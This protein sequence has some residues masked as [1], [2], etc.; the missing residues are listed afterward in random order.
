MMFTNATKQNENG[1]AAADHKQVQQK[2]QNGLSMSRNKSSFTDS[3]QRRKGPLNGNW[4]IGSSASKPGR[5]QAKVK[6]GEAN[7]KYEKEA[8]AMADKVMS[9]P[10]KSQTVSNG[11]QNSSISRKTENSLISKI[12]PLTQRKEDELQNKEEEDVQEKS[13]TSVQTKSTSAGS[14]TPPST[15]QRLSSSSSNNEDIQSMLQPMADEAQTK[16]FQTQIDS[17]STPNIQTDAE[18]ETARGPPDSF[19]SSLNSSKGG[20]SPLPDETQHDM[21][22][23]FGADFSNVRVHTDS[24]AV[25]M[26]K[27]IGAQA[28]AHGSDIYFNEGKY[29]PDTNSG[30]HLL[31]HELTHTIQQGAVVRPYRAQMKAEATGPIV[32]RAGPNPLAVDKDE[33]DKDKGIEKAVQ[34]RAGPNFLSAPVMVQGGW[35]GDKLNEYASDIPGWTL[36]TVVVGYNPLTERDIERTPQ[37]FLKGLMGLVPGGNALYEKL[38]DHGLISEAFTWLNSQLSDLDLSWRRVAREMEEAWDEMSIRYSFST[39]L[40]IVKDHLYSIYRDVKEFGKRIID[41]TIELVKKA[42]LVPLGEYIRDN[43]RAWPLV[44]VLLG[45]DPISGERVERNL[46]NIASGFLMLDP[47]GEAYLNKLNESGKLQELSDW[48]DLEL[49]KLNINADTI[50]QVFSAAWDLITLDN[51]LDPINT[52]KKIFN[53]FSGPFERIINFVIAVAIK[54]LTAIKDWL[55]GQ[56]KTHAHKVPGY[57]LLTVI[58]GKDPVTQEEVPRTAENFI[59]GFMSF[60]PGGLEKFENLKKSGAIDKAFAWLEKAVAKLNLSFEAFLQ[61]FVTLWESF[62]INDLLDPIGAFEKIINIFAAPVLRIIDFAIEVGLK[63]LE[64]IFTG[65]MGSTGGRVVAIMKKTR[66]TFMKIIKNPVGFFQNLLKAIVKGFKQFGNNIFQHLLS[67]LAGWLFGALEGAGLQLPDKWDFKG[68]LSIVMQVLGLTWERVRAK[69]VKH[70]GERTVARLETAFEFVKIIATEGLAGVWNKIMEYLTGLKD[71]VFEGIRNWVVTKIVTVAIQKLATMWNPVGAVIESIIA[72]YNTVMFFI[73]RLNQILDLVESIVDSIS[74]IANGSLEQAANYVEQTMART[75]P[76][77]ISFLARLIGLGGISNAIK[78]VIK[79]IQDVV[80]LGLDKLIGWVV[81]QSRRLMDRLRG[82]GDPE[83]QNA[84]DATNMTPDQ[85]KEGARTEF[86]TWLRGGRRTGAQIKGQLPGLKQKYLLSDAKVDLS[87][88]SPRIAFFASPAIYTYLDPSAGQQTVRDGPAQNAPAQFTSTNAMMS[89]P[90]PL[91]VI[92]GTYSATVLEGGFECKASR[93]DL[94]KSVVAEKV[95]YQSHR[96]GSSR[97]PQGHALKLGRDDQKIVTGRSVLTFNGGHLVSDEILTTPIADKSYNLAPQVRQFNSPAYYHVIEKAAG[98]SLPSNERIKM[99]VNLGYSQTSYPVSQQTL[100]DRGMLSRVDDTKP[101][102]ISLPVRIPTTWNARLEALGPS[103]RLGDGG[104]SATSSTARHG[105]VVDNQAAFDTLE[106]DTDGS[107]SNRGRHHFKMLIKEGGAVAAN[108]SISTGGARGSIQVE[109]VQTTPAYPSSPDLTPRP[110]RRTIPRQ[111]SR[112]NNRRSRGR[113]TYDQRSNIRRGRHHQGNRGGHRGGRRKADPS[114]VQSDKGL[115]SSKDSYE[116][117]ADRVADHVVAG[118]KATVVGMPPISKVQQSSY[119][120]LPGRVEEPDKSGGQA[121]PDKT[122]SEMEIGIGADFSKVKVHTDSKAVQMSKDMGARA[123]AHGNDIYFNSGQY[124]PQ[125]NEGKHLLAH[126]LTHTVQQGA[127][128]PSVQKAEDPSAS[129][130]APKEEKPININFAPADNPQPTAA[131]LEEISKESIDT[132]K[133][134]KGEPKKSQAP[135]AAA[136]DKPK[137]KPVLKEKTEAQEK[138]KKKK[139]SKDSAKAKKKD[140][141]PEAGMNSFLN[142]PASVLAGQHD[143]IGEA[144]ANAFGS[145]RQK[146][147]AETPAVVA[148][149]S[150][151]TETAENT[152]TLEA[153]KTKGELIDGVT[154][155][156]PQAPKIGTHKDLAPPP[157]PEKN[158]SLLDKQKLGAFFSWFRNSFSGYLGGIATKDNG[159]NTSAGKRPKANLSG[160]SDPQRAVNQQKDGS[161]KAEDQNKEVKGSIDKNPGEKNIQPVE[162]KEENKISIDQKKSKVKTE[163]KKEMGDY[164]NLPLPKDVRDLTDQGMS[165]LLSKSLSKPKEDV[166]AATSKRDTDRKSEM[167]KAQKETAKLNQDAAVEQKKTVDDN[168]KAVLDQKKAGKDEA[169]KLK[170]GF[171]KQ[172]SNKKKETTDNIDKEVKTREKEADSELKKGETKAKEKKK[173]AEKKAKDKKKELKKSSK[174]KS[175]WERAVDAV[176]SAVKAITSAIGKIFSALRKAVSAII[177]AAKELALK[178]IDAARQFAL[179]ALD[180][181]G[182]FLKGLVNTFIGSLFPDLAKRINKAIDDKVSKA[183][184]AV[185]AVADKLKKGVTALADALKKGL[186]KILDAFETALTAAVQIVGALVTGDFVEALKIAIRSACKIAGI[187]PNTVFNFIDKAG[188]T[189]MKILKDPISF[190]KNVASGIG[191]GINKFKTNIKKHLINGLFG[192]LTG[193]MNDVPIQLPNKWDLKGIMSVVL[194]ILGL[195]YDNLR[196]KVVKKLGPKGETIVGALEKTAGILQQLYKAKSAKP[197]IDMAKA[198]FGELK[199]QAMEK[200]RGV[201]TLEVVKAGIKWLIGLL[202]PASAIVKAVIMVFDVSMFLIERKD[203]IITFVKSVYDTIAPLAN[204]Q[205]GKA[206]AFIEKAMGQSV[207]VILGL[208][209]NLAGIGGIGKSISKVIKAIRKPVDKIVDPIIGGIVNFGKKLFKG[210]AKGSQSKETS[211]SK[212]LKEKILKEIRQGLKKNKFKNAKQ[213]DKYLD[214]IYAKYKKLGAKYIKIDRSGKGKFK[215]VVSASPESSYVTSLEELIYAETQPISHPELQIVKQ[216]LSKSGSARKAEDKAKVKELGATRDT[217]QTYSVLTLNGVIQ[218]KEQDKTA[219]EVMSTNRPGNRNDFEMMLTDLNQSPEG[220]TLSAHLEGVRQQWRKL[221]IDQHK[222]KKVDLKYPKENKSSL[223]SEEI[224][225]RSSIWYNTLNMASNNLKNKYSGDKPFEESSESEKISLILNR[226][227]CGNCSQV[228][229]TQ[230]NDFKQKYRS[231][232]YP[233]PWFA[234]QSYLNGKEQYNHVKPNIEKN[235]LLNHRFNFTLAAQGK[236]RGT[237]IPRTGMIIGA[238]WNVK[239]FPPAD[240]APLKSR[241]SGDHGLTLTGKRLLE[242]ILNAME[243]AISKIKKQEDAQRNELDNVSSGPTK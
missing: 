10:S 121:L 184:K 8:D 216:H 161:D 74:N 180:A 165:P 173:D 72:I 130:D 228:V 65:V 138:G 133:K 158:D 207:P 110:R 226:S 118:Q 14:E 13:Q 240:S 96:R 151:K 189:V 100:V 20:G 199:E 214:S 164:L 53:L 198:K 70:L 29:A 115:A 229:T 224:L 194:Q 231:N 49:E 223:H 42:I 2:E 61:L 156:D 205:V 44:T 166:A 155:A 11:E 149:N 192:W 211:K 114:L 123:F 139:Q 18:S 134:E 210:K 140:D 212:G 103:N 160:K 124:N 23:S 107:N 38:E 26:N 168:R 37:N 59:K 66:S 81:R 56:L 45:E 220:K 176:K 117:E 1:K 89:A 200:I 104:V 105:R 19:E 159:V 82:R 204:G 157:N 225:L 22:S 222:D 236:H 143:S 187:N 179:K 32:Q 142:A 109:A 90:T 52:F 170:D 78:N 6:I 87:G 181:F 235:K 152:G 33:I 12:T 217:G 102:Q 175:W 9:M 40:G 219:Y 208:L 144:T 85:K 83:A 25:Q 34:A 64:F 106:L 41:K 191:S 98:S 91:Q 227:S 3:V 221:Y 57:P 46:Y 209:A 86:E 51:L 63:V 153:G 77:I 215:I 92:R 146:V 141:S 154:S 108:G 193:A 7:D 183:K 171:E 242:T 31:A 148:D 62:T 177:D 243:T 55:I 58:L 129:P 126:E 80:D 54:I 182:N 68:I 93:V 79:K 95:G 5:M 188:N 35:L 125:S 201:V 48:F 88:D 238:G 136:K 163:K 195:T 60:V 128:K 122:R 169:Q 28:F 16:T 239:V 172:S 112:R 190:V 145:Q 147:E 218:G 135:P 30:K 21:G 230:L 174:K 234:D 116:H 4:S 131:A 43:T 24:N 75:L 206:A 213:V 167:D 17:A 237:T 99:T 67:G 119:N 232:N 137:E 111:R 36:I 233:L 178:A 47:D 186:N 39:N 185:N 132:G 197:L 50:T 84:V 113:N 127:S 162:V 203:Q 15:A 120:D 150:G 76:V 71:K 73:E 101:E 241:T 202:N 196:A 27:Q 69:L 94:P 97:G